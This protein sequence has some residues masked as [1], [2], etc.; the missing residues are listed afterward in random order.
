MENILEYSHHTERESI[1]N[2]NNYCIFVH[3]DIPVMLFIYRH[4]TKYELFI[5]TKLIIVHLLL[6]I[7]LQSLNFPPKG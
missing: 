1:D 5:H 3:A 6:C 4:F 7:D 2:T